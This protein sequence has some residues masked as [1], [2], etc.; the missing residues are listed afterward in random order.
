MTA[1]TIDER[2]ATAASELRAALADTDVPPLRAADPAVD[3]VEGVDGGEPRERS[4]RRTALVAVAAAVTAF[5]L[6]GVVLR[7][8]GGDGVRVAAPEPLTR[9]EWIELVDTQC[10]AARARPELPTDDLA[11]LVDGIA[12]E[13]AFVALLRSTSARVLERGVPTELAAV[14][15]FADDALG[16][17][18]DTL[19][20]VE[21]AARDGD[22]SRVTAELQESDSLAD[23]LYLRLTD[24]GALACAPPAP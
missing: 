8:D 17:I 16:A 15:A 22:A 6:G 9:T 13:R 12:D 14:S 24:A 23:R 10:R 7:D 2:A 1:A 4:G 5:V 18:A 11:A 20:R 3:L 19:A 21:A